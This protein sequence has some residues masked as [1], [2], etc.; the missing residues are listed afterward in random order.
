MNLHV[1]QF[2]P[3]K[4]DTTPNQ[5]P[6]CVHLAPKELSDPFSKRQ[7]VKAAGC[8]LKNIL[9]TAPWA[10]KRHTNTSA[11]AHILSATAKPHILK[12][13]KIKDPRKQKLSMT[14]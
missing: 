10:P 3:Q 1:G 6:I 11:N 4:M 8:K 12:G 7:R 9:C 14:N 5:P 2:L 13:K